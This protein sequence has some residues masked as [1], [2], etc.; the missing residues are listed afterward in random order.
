MLDYNKTYDVIV[1]GGGH[2]GCEAALA[3]ARMGAPTLLLTGNVDMIGHMSCNPAIGGLAKGHLVREIDA[4]GG[5]MGKAIDAS[6]IQY[7]RL[8]T[9]KGPAVRATRA[10]ADRATYMKTIKRTLESQSNLEIK[11]HIVDELIVEAKTVKGVK[12]A[13]GLNFFAKKVILTTGTFLN[14]LMHIGLT[15]FEGGRLGDFCAKHLSASLIQCGFKLGRLK[16]GTVPRLDGKT[17][18]YSSLVEQ[19]GDEPRPRFS[20]SDIENVLPQKSCFITYTNHDTHEIIRSGLDRSPLYTGKIEGV[21]PRYCPSIEDKIVRFADKERH[22]IFLE[23]EG[24][25][26]D[27]IYA[28]GIPTSLPIDIQIRLVHSIPGLE[29]AEIV[30][31]GYAVEYDY[32][33]PTQL[34]STLE[35]KCVSGLYHAGQINGTS[36]Y[37]EAAAQGLMAAINAVL[38]VRGEEPLVLDRSQAYI[39]VLIDD[40]VTKGTQEPYCMFTSRAEYRLLLRE[41]NADLRLREIGRKMELVNDD[42]WNNFR[43]KRTQ[44][45][46]LE[47]YL[48]NTR[49]F[50]NKETNTKFSDIGLAGLKNVATLKEIVRRPEISI[51]TVFEHFGTGVESYSDE[52][53][54]QVEIRTKYEGYIRAQEEGV[55][56]L[57]KMEELVI[58]ENF[59]YGEVENLS[60]EV[61]EKLCSIKPRTLG[62]A[63]RISG[64]TPAALSILM[65]H[66]K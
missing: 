65:V 57:K 7:R 38:S 17:I 6:G 25:D 49:V 14:G 20:F 33:T 8:N 9:K 43:E 45:N 21:G 47:D 11:Q 42:D 13:I 12:T 2:A 60:R 19:F 51:K 50:P 59:N 41:D 36:G 63:S 61:R 16:T 29:H 54:E 18:D 56:R 23:P 66:L 27:E 53:L 1:V 24:V 22:Q 4:L 31:P 28:N 44:I 48:K 64:I 37:E 40:L 58:P 32:A 5:E 39:G 34:K 62:Q 26:T 30:R 10:Q 3:S 35:A 46:R 55:V 15:T 52:A